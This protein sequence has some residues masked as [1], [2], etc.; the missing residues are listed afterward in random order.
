L[1]EAQQQ[2]VRQEK[3]AV[4]GELAGSVGHELL[5][6]L[7]VISN[8]V[9]FLKVVQ[10]DADNKVK[11]YLDLIENHIRISDKI[12]NDLL[13]FTWTK[14]AERRAVSISN[15]LQ[16]ALEYSPAPRNVQV[17]LDLP[18]DLPPVYADPKHVMKILGNLILN[19]YQAMAAKGGLLTLSARVDA[20]RGMVCVDV[21]DTG[22]GIAPENMQ[23]LFEPLFTTKVKGI[24][25][26]LAVC[27]KLLEA[28]S[29]SIEVQ[30][31]PGVGSMFSVYIPLA[32]AAV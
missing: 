1:R 4:L 31:E 19:A 11:E 14:P 13:D 10:P 23:K 17:T 30:S 7:G 16:Q 29:G 5:N 25:L 20:P 27:K 12:V 24:G 18:A 15:A 32:K 22:V 8:A 3:L 9:Y 6:P 26:G 2:L 28:N 21:R